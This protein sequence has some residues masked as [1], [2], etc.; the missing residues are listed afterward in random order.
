MLAL[1]L[2]ITMFACADREEQSPEI[3]DQ[4]QEM[5]DAMTFTAQAVSQISISPGVKKEMLSY[6]LDEFGGEV[7]AHFSSLLSNEIQDQ[8][9]SQDNPKGTFNRLF[10]S[11]A[12]EYN[13]ERNQDRSQS[14]SF[15]PSDLETYLKQNN[16]AV[17]APYYAE[18]HAN[19]NSTITVTFDPLDDT[20]TSNI[21]YKLVRKANTGSSANHGGLDAS[22]SIDDYDMTEVPNVD[23]DYAY[24]NPTWVVIPDDG[25]TNL[26]NIYS[27]DPGIG[28][29]PSEANARD[30]DCND[31]TS[32]H[33]VAL[34][35][36][37][38]R[39]TGNFSSAIWDRN[40]LHLW[41]ATGE[42][43]FVD[44][45]P[46]LGPNVNKLWGEFKISRA[47]ARDQ[48]W[49]STGLSHFERDWTEEE[50]DLFFVI[51]RK[52][53][54]ELTITGDV[55]FTKDGVE[56]NVD[57]TINSENKQ[58]LIVKDNL[59]RCDYLATHTRPT[60]LGT[61]AG[62]AV[63]GYGK[64]QFYWIPEIIDLND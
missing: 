42:I 55:K 16:L 24:E 38:V 18:N 47:D 10:K 30:I 12:A 22:F 27:D 51:T 28:G 4:R 23:D 62:Q 5:L 34:R 31:L 45:V 19:S 63:Q 7:T 43:T 46:Q 32:N 36:P 3:I 9:A 50:T 44:N 26:G 64:V 59:N 58:T 11:K 54:V 48:K 14:S 57:V 35:M 60:S 49:V 17:Y 8:N 1:V 13:V 52:R 40:L 41:V 61:R 2:A 37:E 6:A 15:D 29:A 39:L 56:A 20:K 33:V 21:G 53:G 25:N